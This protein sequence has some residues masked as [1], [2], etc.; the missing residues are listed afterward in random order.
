MHACRREGR[1]SG[2]EGSPGPSPPP[3]TKSAGRQRGRSDGGNP[4][5]DVDTTFERRHRGGTRSACA[6]CRR[7]CNVRLLRVVQ[8][9]AQHVRQPAAHAADA[10]ANRGAGPAST[11]RRRPG[12]GRPRRRAAVGVDFLEQRP[13]GL[14][15]DTVGQG[16]TGLRSVGCPRGGIR[17]PTTLRPVT[18]VRCPS[19]AHAA[20]SRSS[21]VCFALTPPTYCPMDPSPRTTRWHGITTGSGLCAQAEP[22]ARTAR[23]LP[24]AAA[25]AP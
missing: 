10:M 4:A 13:P 1:G 15:G 12:S 14:S 18:V 7:Q 20:A 21:N 9:E 6:A 8:H 19:F 2:G 24:T 5:P 22:T 25:T 3:T 17:V 23:G 11:R 16:S